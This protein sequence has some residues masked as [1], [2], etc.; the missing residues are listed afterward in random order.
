LVAALAYSRL[1]I[2]FDE[3]IRLASPL[4]ISRPTVLP[5]FPDLSA[6]ASSGGLLAIA[7]ASLASIQDRLPLARHTLPSA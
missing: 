1:R 4:E 5:A 7:W 2:S 3:R 6:I